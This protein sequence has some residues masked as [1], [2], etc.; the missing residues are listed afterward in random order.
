MEITDP[1]PLL[2]LTE[3][4]R[5]LR[6]SYDSARRYFRHLPGVLVKQHVSRFKRPYRIY[7]VPASVFR[8]EWAKMAAFNSNGK[9]AA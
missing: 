7:M 8:R 6:W 9:K 5:S 2:T 4:A 1:E 3:V